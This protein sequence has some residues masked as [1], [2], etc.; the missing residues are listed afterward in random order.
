MSLLKFLAM[1]GGTSANWLDY[2][3]TNDGTAITFD[4]EAG[5]A[6]K[7]D[8]AAIDSSSL[9][10]VH[11]VNSQ[12]TIRARVVSV[13][14]L[15][16]TLGTEV[17]SAT[18]GTISSLRL[19]KLSETKY[20]VVLG[21]NAVNQLKSIVVEVSAGTPSFG[22]VVIHRT[23]NDGSV[24]GACALDDSRV[25][26]CYGREPTGTNAGVI[27]VTGTVPLIGVVATIGTSSAQIF[28][29]DCDFLDTDKVA[30][31]W[32]NT[33]P[34]NIQ[35]VICT[36]SG[37][38]VTA[39]TIENST[40]STP[41]STIPTKLVAQGTGEYYITTVASSGWDT[42]RFTVSGTTIT[43]V[44]STSVTP[45]PASTATGIDALIPQADVLFTAGAMSV[46]QV[47]QRAI[48]ISSTPAYQTQVDETVTSGNGAAMAQL[49]ATRI[50][51]VYQT[52]NTNTNIKIL[53]GE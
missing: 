29:L 1:S 38:T 31:C 20:L 33:T 47:S 41:A 35:S 21:L 3:G 28:R 52:T 49:D 32:L 51:F 50:G 46:S 27:T 19:V 6:D 4:A 53:N 26:V 13:S 40:A 39:G 10:V 45:S 48:D 2:D 16:P 11:Q 17:V 25:F 9:L 14:D 22:T 18:V 42:F 34:S 5:P 37:S 12:P 44:D 15:T 30:A 36:I 24:F 43:E 8:I 23:D 7:I